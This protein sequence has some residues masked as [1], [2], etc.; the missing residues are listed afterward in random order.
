MEEFAKESQSNVEN[1]ES[2]QKEK[3]KE[4]EGNLRRIRRTVKTER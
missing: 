4:K 2:Q 1:K 3:E